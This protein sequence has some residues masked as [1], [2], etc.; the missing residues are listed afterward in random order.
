[1]RP[2]LEPQPEQLKLIV[3]EESPP[4]EA[5]ARSFIA[6]YVFQMGWIDC[7]H[8]SPRGQSTQWKRNVRKVT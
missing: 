4:S 5:D 3:I 7:E 8:N 2:R 6:A 1:M